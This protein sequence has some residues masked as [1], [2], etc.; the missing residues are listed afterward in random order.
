MSFQSPRP[1]RARLAATLVADV[2]THLRASELRALLFRAA[3]SAGRPPSERLAARTAWVHQ[4][5]DV[6]SYEFDLP[7]P[8][9]ANLASLSIPNLLPLTRVT[10]NSV[11]KL[12]QL[13]ARQHNHYPACFH[14]PNGEYLYPVVD[15][16]RDPA[17]GLLQLL[18]LELYLKIEPAP[19]V[20]CL[21]RLY[22]AHA[23]AVSPRDYD[24]PSRRSVIGNVFAERVLHLLRPVVV[25]AFPCAARHL[26]ATPVSFRQLV[27]LYVNRSASEPFEPRLRYTLLYGALR[28]EAAQNL[29]MRNLFLHLRL[30]G[31]D[32]SDPVT[33]RAAFQ[34][35]RR[36]FGVTLDA[37]CAHAAGTSDAGTSDSRIALVED[38]AAFLFEL[39]VQPL[40]ALF[41]GIV[42]PGRGALSVLYN[43]RRHL[44][45]RLALVADIKSASQFRKMIRNPPLDVRGT[46]LH[47]PFCAPATR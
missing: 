24:D 12:A 19:C 16:L 21:H 34:Y 29:G 2:R 3:S 28:A 13:V 20:Y 9:V 25:R 33:A 18:V 36:V 7:G 42:A 37:W 8:L 44:L 40:R 46:G 23:H 22:A 10:R 32:V 15:S 4:I 5:R 17:D 45:S 14:A 11:L 43:Q 30:M 38:A 47:C 26:H 27:W 31:L 1:K 41:W 6:C 35:A 39:H